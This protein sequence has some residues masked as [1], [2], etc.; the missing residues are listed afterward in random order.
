MTLA[1]A[2]QEADK[3]RETIAAGGDPVTERIVAKAKLRTATGNTFETVA[4]AML[5]AK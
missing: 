3:V 2:R 1:K 4:T 5:S